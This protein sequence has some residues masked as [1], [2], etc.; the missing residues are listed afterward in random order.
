MCWLFIF[1]SLSSLHLPG[2]QYKGYYDC[3]TSC[4]KPW[5]IWLIVAFSIIIVFIGLAAAGNYAK[6][7]RLMREQA[8]AEKQAAEQAAAQAAAQEQNAQQA[9]QYYDAQKGYPP[10]AYSYPVPPA[11][12]PAAPGAPAPAAV[13][14]QV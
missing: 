13:A 10:P 6:K 4:P 12:V 11:P 5:W 1:I 2:G 8:E 9:A 7:Q 3:G 14:T